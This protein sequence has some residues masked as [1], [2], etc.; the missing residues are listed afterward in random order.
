MPS[1]STTTL[2]AVT[3]SLA[4]L[5]MCGLLGLWLLRRHRRTP[6]LSY[7]ILTEY[8]LIGDGAQLPPELTVAIDGQAI[9]DLSIVVVRIANDGVVAL[10]PAA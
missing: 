2:P 9:T 4:V 7:H 3:S 5:I 10:R 6:S 1:V 8:Q